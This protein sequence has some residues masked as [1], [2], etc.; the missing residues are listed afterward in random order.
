MPPGSNAGLSWTIGSGQRSPSS[1]SLVDV[2]G[3][4]LV[5]DVDEA[6]RVVRVVVDEAL[7]KIEDVQLALP[8]VW[9]SATRSAIARLSSRVT[10]NDDWRLVLQPMTWTASY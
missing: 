1:S 5:A 6:A 10:P 9:S 4:P 8:G 7:A 2:L 3:D